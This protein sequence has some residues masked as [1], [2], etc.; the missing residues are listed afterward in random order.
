MRFNCCNHITDSVSGSQEANQS[1]SWTNHSVETTN[2]L[3]RFKWTITFHFFF[4]NL[5]IE[6]VIKTDWIHLWIRHHYL[7]SHG[8]AMSEDGCQDFQFLWHELKHSVNAIW[9]IF[10][11]HFCPFWSLK[12]SA[13]S[14]CN[15]I[16]TSTKPVLHNKR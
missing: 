1:N 2:S 11:M 9:T 5:D 12:A 4:L 13:L 8:W 16:K 6:S 15:C 10:R 7:N 14:Y 3:K